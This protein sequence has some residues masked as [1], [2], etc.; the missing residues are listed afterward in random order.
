MEENQENKIVYLRLDDIIPNRFQPREIFDSQGLEELANSIKEHGVIQPIVVREV[1]G[2]YELIAGERRTKASALAGLTTI[3]AIIKNMDDKESAKVSL[4][5]NLQRKNLSAIEEARTYKRIIELDNMTQEELARTMGKSQPMVANKLRL[6]M[7]PDEVQDA[8]MKNEISERHARSLLTLSNKKD[9]L[10]FLEKIKKERLTVRELDKELKKFKENKAIEPTEDLNENEEGS[11][12]NN[13]V[14]FGGMGLNDYQS[15]INNNNPNNFSNMPDIGNN[16]NTGYN[17]NNFNDNNVEPDNNTMNSYFNEMQEKSTINPAGTSSLG[18]MFDEYNGP[19]PNIEPSNDNSNIFV[20]HIREDN[21]PKSEN[22]FLPN[23]DQFNQSGNNI[24]NE[25][26]VMTM[27][28][29]QNNNYNNVSTN[30]Y[31]NFNQPNTFNN[32]NTGYNMPNDIQQNNYN[33]F[34][35]STMGMNNYNSNNY[36]ANDLNNNINNQQTSFNYGINQ[37]INN[38]ESSYNMPNYNNGMN[39]M[40]QQNQGAMFSQPLNIVDVPNENNIPT[41]SDFN[42]NINNYGPV[43]NSMNAVNN[44]NFNDIPSQNNNLNN[45]NQMGNNNNEENYNDMMFS[46]TVQ[47]APK[48][49]NN[50]EVKNTETKD[51]NYQNNINDSMENVSDSS[52]PVSQ[53]SA[54]I[55][56]ETLEKNETPEEINDNYVRLETPSTIKDPYS[57]VLELKK[58]TDLIK[59]NN[60]DIETEEIDF[61]DVYQIVIKIKKTDDI[62]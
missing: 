34:N 21:L 19:T 11:I 31:N 43:P 9:Q 44:Y 3:P 36:F 47:M 48:D 46:K 32:I 10:F 55:Q 24:T 49:E 15:S 29:N 7:L 40:Y 17:Y 30:D 1:G 56:N 41:N 22:Q 20:S 5:E 8:L 62:I 12:M 37:G 6:L 38:F 60:I 59:Q 25:T 23:F 33:N 52:I 27:N 61:D 4:L 13:R 57:A 54:E 50:L 42:Q 16:V 53:E 2:K 39:Q 14:N 18:S 58:T 35:Q 28:N 26:P 51:L 45:L